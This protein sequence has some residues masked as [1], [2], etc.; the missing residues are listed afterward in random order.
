M[1]T[2]V[3]SGNE[4]TFCCWSSVAALTASVP[5]TSTTLPVATVDGNVFSRP[6]RS[7]AASCTMTGN[8]GDR[9]KSSRAGSKFNTTARRPFAE[10]V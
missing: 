5:G 8:H 7:T 1:L 4:L 9:K 10:Q 6:V 3:S 2:G